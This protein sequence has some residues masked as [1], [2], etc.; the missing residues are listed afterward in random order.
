MGSRGVILSCDGNEV[1]SISTI[2]QHRMQ[3]KQTKDGIT[4]LRGTLS[5]MFVI[6]LSTMITLLPLA[7]MPIHD[8]GTG[9]RTMLWDIN[10]ILD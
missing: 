3:L 8:G 6:H 2:W 5:L 4:A 9:M 7:Q 1:A 10:F